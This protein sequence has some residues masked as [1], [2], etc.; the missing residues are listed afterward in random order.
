MGIPS[1]ADLSIGIAAGSASVAAGDDVV[2]T[3][4]L[5]NAGP[6]QA[7]SIVV[8]EAFTTA[9]GEPSAPVAFT[10]STGSYNPTTGVWTIGALSATAGTP[11]TLALTFAAPAVAEPLVLEASVASGTADGNPSNNTD[12]DSVDVVLP[13]GIFSDGFED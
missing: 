10:A 8:E 13:E 9:G 4:T 12:S 6:D 5:G 11:A 2:F 7:V 3:L 1:T